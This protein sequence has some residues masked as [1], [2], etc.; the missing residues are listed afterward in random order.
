MTTL[1]RL[2]ADARR[3]ADTL[4]RAALEKRA[5]DHQPR[6]FEEALVAAAPAVIAEIKR[7]SPSG[8]VLHA[9]LDPAALAAAY[10]R[11]GAAAISVLTEPH[12][13]DGSE[14]DLRAVSAAVGVPVLRKDFTVDPIQVVEAAAMGADAVLAIVAALDD[15]ALSAVMETA[16]L[17]GLDVL[18]EVHDRDEIDR[19]RSAGARIVG[20]NARNLRTFDV[21]LDLVVSLGESVD[22]AP[23]RV[24]ESGIRDRSDLLRMADAGFNAV[25][26]G[27][28][29]VR[30]GDPEATL[31][32]LLG[33]S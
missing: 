4:D 3:R 28:S 23:I 17:F 16:E 20:V 6:R 22:F 26:V 21:D 1:D 25:L 29:L 11:G 2:V 12:H 31:A 27:E 33:S 19:A 10:V 13:F 24:A 7:R 9:D 18:V 30:S 14:D 8:G 5:A 15:A 32:A